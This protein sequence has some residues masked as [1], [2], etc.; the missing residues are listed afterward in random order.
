MMQEVE[1]AAGAAGTQF[2]QR[3]MEWHRG[4]NNRALPWKDETDPY[5]IWLSEIILQQTR[6]EQGRPYYERF[7]NAYP[8]VHALAAAPEQEAFKHWEGLGYYAR[9]RNMLKTAKDVSVNKA[10]IFPDSYDGL[11]ALPGVG[12]YT[13]AA[14]ASFA[15]GLPHAVLDGNVYRVLARYFGV[16][17][18]TDGTAGKTLFQSLADAVL[19]RG[20]PAGFN[21]AIMDFGATVCSPALPLCRECPL[22]ENCVALRAGLVSELPVRAKKAPLRQRWFHYLIVRHNGSIWIRQRL[23]KDIWNGLFEPYLIESDAPMERRDLAE[24]DAF[25]GECAP[26]Y[27]GSLSQKL[28]HQQINSRF[29]VLDCDTLPPMPEDGIWVPAAHL[30]EFAFPKSVLNFFEKNGYF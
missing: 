2:T 15:Y 17:H 28:S 27:G 24:N 23:A 19:D 13:A 30:A 4:S 5:R 18:G 1:A 22:S 3:L 9:C 21:Q 6:A 20:D 25:P 16:M 11:L 26:E 8:D 29:F 12:P 10:G 14:I 7:K